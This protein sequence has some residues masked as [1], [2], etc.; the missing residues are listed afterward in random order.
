MIQGVNC[1]RG[2]WVNRVLEEKVYFL[3]TLVLTLVDSN[4]VVVVLRCKR[5]RRRR[6]RCGVMDKLLIE[7]S[8]SQCF[9][10]FFLFIIFIFF[11]PRRSQVNRSLIV[12]VQVNCALIV[13]DDNQFWLRSFRFGSVTHFAILAGYFTTGWLLFFFLL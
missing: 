1:V 5:N 9:F 13:T 2:Y 7:L 11:I 12:R 4:V 3:G 6:L 8:S 10:F